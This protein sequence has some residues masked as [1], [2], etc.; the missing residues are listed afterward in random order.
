LPL[1]NSAWG[2]VGLPHTVQGPRISS[3]K[4]WSNVMAALPNIGGALCPT[5]QSL[6][7]SRSQ[8]CRQ[9]GKLSKQSRR[10]HP[11]VVQ[12]ATYPVRELSSPWVDQ[13]ARCPV[14]ESSSPR[15]GNPRFGVFASCPVTPMPHNQVLQN[16]CQ[17]LQWLPRF[18]LN[19]L[20]MRSSMNRTNNWVPVYGRYNL[21]NFGM[22][23]CQIPT[24]VTADIPKM[25]FN[26]T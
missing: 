21:N 13:S 22:C 4:M 25:H 2:N 11:R 8:R 17:C 26:K 10:W 18:Q 5:P 23:L 6:A 3:T 7:D 1:P 24:V 15:V 19:Y 9:T 12:S 16:I 20:E 14:R